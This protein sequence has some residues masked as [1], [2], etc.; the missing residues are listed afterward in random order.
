MNSKNSTNNKLQTLM[1]KCD[2]CNMYFLP[3][4]PMHTLKQQL[5]KGFPPRGTAP[6]EKCMEIE[7]LKS[8]NQRLSTEI[9]DLQQTITNLRYIRVIEKEIDQTLVD[10]SSSFEEDYLS[11]TETNSNSTSDGVLDLLKQFDN[12]TLSDKPDQTGDGNTKTIDDSFET[13]DD[14]YQTTDDEEYYGDQ[15]FSDSE[16]EMFTPSK[17][18]ETLQEGEDAALP[19][20][21][22][23]KTLSSESDF[24]ESVCNSTNLSENAVNNQSLNDESYQENMIH[25]ISHNSTVCKFESENEVH[26][27]LAGDDSFKDLKLDTNLV[28]E[29]QYFKV[30]RTGAS[31]EELMS[32][33]QFFMHKLHKSTKNVIIQLTSHASK[34]GRT[35]N[36][37]KD[38]HN[39][40]VAMNEANIN[41]GICGPLPYPRLS[42]QAYARAKNINDWLTEHCHNYESCAYIDYFHLMNNKK[43]MFTADG[44]QLSPVGNWILKECINQCYSN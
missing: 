27:I 13:I 20:G 8:Q 36:I 37:K 39:F 31:T 30:A 23:E 4:N 1:M 29:R 15:E 18:D 24:Q 41:V 28:Q 6:C 3:P 34:N 40:I 5:S 22:E 14:N 35:E 2:L 16:A 7:E 25:N 11:S 44:W 33:A 21:P 17:N 42:N 9:S 38:L 12:W 19:K 43:E 26:T 10:I 32:T